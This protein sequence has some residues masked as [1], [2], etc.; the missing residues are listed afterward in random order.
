[1]CVGKEKVANRFG[2]PFHRKMEKFHLEDLK[3]GDH[4]AQERCGT[5]WHHM[6][7][8]SVKKAEPKPIKVIH[9]YGGETIFSGKGSTVCDTLLEYT[10]DK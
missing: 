8:E 4:I 10:Q 3:P 9:Y 7:V 5:F 6:I 1:M 2:R